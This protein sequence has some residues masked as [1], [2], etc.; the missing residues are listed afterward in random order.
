MSLWYAPTKLRVDQRRF[1][2]AQKVVV[3]VAAYLHSQ[4]PT[5]VTDL[6]SGQSFYS[7]VTD[8]DGNLHPQ[9]SSLLV[10]ATSLIELLRDGRQDP[11]R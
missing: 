4:Q 8:E 2:Q 7:I 5:V 6:V 11:F 3:A 9:R 1:R 10:F